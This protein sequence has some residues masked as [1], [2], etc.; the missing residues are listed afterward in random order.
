MRRR[1]EWLVVVGIV[2]L[3]VFAALAIFLM[4]RPAAG[5]LVISN[6]TARPGDVLDVTVTLSENEAQYVAASLDLILPDVLD[7]G[8]TA[9]CAFVGTHDN[10][11]VSIVS[12]GPL[13]SVVR[14]IALDFETVEFPLPP[15]EL[16]RCR[17]R[18]PTD[19]Q[20]GRYVIGCA[21][22]H[23]TTCA[24]AVTRDCATARYSLTCPSAVALIEVPFVPSPSPTATAVPPT[25]T[26]VVAGEP[27]AAQG[28]EYV[29][30]GSG[31]CQ[32]SEA[33]GTLSGAA[34]F[35][36]GLLLALLVYPR[37]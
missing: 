15:G 19:A 34:L 7:P 10:G 11:G 31:G 37:R 27:V 1:H 25:P 18:V 26:R 9:A 2:M 22:A 13:G 28:V 30:G 4:P 16:V 8:A 29:S 20:P 23:A 5:Q 24:D 14:L 17:V 35:A 12:R 32:V 33:D 36:L 21:S 6:V 3:S